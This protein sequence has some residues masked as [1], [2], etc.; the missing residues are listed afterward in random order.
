MWLLPPSTSTS[1]AWVLCVNLHNCVR[2]QQ[3][4]RC[5][6]NRPVEITR[7]TTLSQVTQ[8]GVESSSQHLPSVSNARR[9][10]CGEWERETQTGIFKSIIRKKGMKNKK[11]LE[12]RLQASQFPTPLCSTSTFSCCCSRADYVYPPTTFALVSSSTSA[13]ASASARHYH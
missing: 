13:S 9:S 2:R 11:L 1:T 12:I 10:I 5:Q 3:R 4:V 7:Q 8:R 6:A